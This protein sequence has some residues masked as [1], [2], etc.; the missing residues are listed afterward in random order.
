MFKCQRCECNIELYTQMLEFDCLS[1]LESE[2]AKRTILRNWK[3]YCILFQMPKNGC[4]TCVFYLFCKKQDFLLITGC[5]NIL[6][7][8]DIFCKMNIQQSWNLQKYEEPQWSPCWLTDFSYD[9]LN[10]ELFPFHLKHDSYQCNPFVLSAKFC[11][12]FENCT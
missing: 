12:V 9:H 7:T 5:S 11:E 1:S 4:W 3:I 2:E 10:T 6:F 8:V